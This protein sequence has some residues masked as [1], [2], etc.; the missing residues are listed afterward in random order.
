MYLGE[1]DVVYSRI[2]E[3]LDMSE[4]LLGVVSDPVDVNMLSTSGL[5]WEVSEIV[6][7]SW[8]LRSWMLPLLGVE[9]TVIDR[10]HQLFTYPNEFLVTVGHRG[11][12]KQGSTVC[13]T[14]RNSC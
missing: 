6:F 10:A 9:I 5:P 14:N 7:R 3:R 2:N 13:V 12:D 4:E 1:F 11:S 8:M